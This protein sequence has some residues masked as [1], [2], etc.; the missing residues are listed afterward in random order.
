MMCEIDEQERRSAAEVLRSCIGERFLIDK[1]R[2]ND[3]CA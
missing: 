1:R 3:D 2:V